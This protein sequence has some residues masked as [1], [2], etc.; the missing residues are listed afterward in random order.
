MRDRMRERERGEWRIRERR[1]L[2]SGVRGVRVT[3]NL[4]RTRQRMNEL[5]PVAYP[6]SY[7]FL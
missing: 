4:F 7:V 6:L 3:Y 5:L 1:E 2:D